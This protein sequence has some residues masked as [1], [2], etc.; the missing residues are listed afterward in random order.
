MLAALIIRRSGSPRLDAGRSY[1]SCPFRDFRPEKGCTLVGRIGDRLKAKLRE[2]LLRDW[3]RNDLDDFAI[4]QGDDLAW[5]SD[6]DEDSN[7]V[8]AL[9]VRVA[10]FGH[11]GYVR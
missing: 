2:L 5:R 11:G 4:E 7:P 3:Q 9:D 1:H 6:R 8:V 10:G